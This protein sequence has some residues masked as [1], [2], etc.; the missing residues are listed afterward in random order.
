VNVQQVDL[1]SICWPFEDPTAAIGGAG[2]ELRA[3]ASDDGFE[4]KRPEGKRIQGLINGRAGSKKGRDGSSTTV[5][6][7]VLGASGW[8]ACHSSLWEVWS[9]GRGWLGGLLGKGVPEDV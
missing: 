5:L 7:S 9:L 3:V 8:F 2:Y 1:R 4:R 6:A